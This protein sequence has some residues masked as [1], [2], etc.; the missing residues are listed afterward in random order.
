MSDELRNERNKLVLQKFFNGE[1][2][3]SFRP[4]DSWFPPRPN[5]EK[6]QK[7]LNFIFR[8]EKDGKCYKDKISR[9]LRMVPERS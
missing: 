3:S 8:S 5:I 7:P 1:S 4:M 6:S 2:L 9:H